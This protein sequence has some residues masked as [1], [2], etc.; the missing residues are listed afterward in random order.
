M[1][2]VLMLLLQHRGTR[3]G[4]GHLV[5]DPIGNYPSWR[6]AHDAKA[7]RLRQEATG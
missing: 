1:D 4:V 2:P 5:W 7:E 6:A 3:D